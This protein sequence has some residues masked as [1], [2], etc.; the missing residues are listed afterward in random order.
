[1]STPAELLMSYQ[2]GAGDPEVLL[3]ELRKILEAG[4]PD[5]A[6]SLARV[7]R[8][9]TLAR[10][11][12]VIWSL[13]AARFASATSEL[14]FAVAEAKRAPPSGRDLGSD[15]SPENRGDGLVTW[16]SETLAQ[17]Q[18]LAGE[19]LPDLGSRVQ[20]KPTR[21]LIHRTIWKTLAVAVGIVFT[22]AIAFMATRS[23]D[24]K[25]APSPKLKP[26]RRA[27]VHTACGPMK[28][29]QLEI[30]ERFPP[31]CRAGDGMCQRGKDSEPMLIVWMSGGQDDCLSRVRVSRFYDGVAVRD[32][33]GRESEASA[34][35]NWRDGRY[36]FLFVL[37]GQ[38]ERYT[39]HVPG[40][41]SLEINLTVPQ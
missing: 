33:A 35:G 37:H 19:A 28:I 13:L 34:G 24:G 36:F 41:G 21:R 38:D 17:V 2:E 3:V 32:S 10:S 26:D 30:S 29:D 22:G 20:S 40:S 25:E 23:T 12:G 11:P 5:A 1:V 31:G 16:S 7:I 14:I 27:T 18:Q 4:G 8:D 6:D 15:L 9:Q 39:L